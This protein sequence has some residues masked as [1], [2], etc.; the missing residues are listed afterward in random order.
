[1]VRLLEETATLFIQDA[2]A[3]NTRTADS[4]KSSV[5]LSSVLIALALLLSIVL[6]VI[7]TRLITR[8]LKELQGLMKRAEEG[9]LTASAAYRSKDE[10]GQINTSFNTM[11][12]GLKNMMRGVSESAE[13]LS[14]SSQQMSASADQTAH[15]SQMIA[16]T[17]GEIAAG[18]DV[19]AESITL[20]TQSV[21]TMS[22]EIAEA[23][24]SG[25]EMT[26]LMEQ[27]ASST[28]RGV[29]AVEQILAQ[30]REID[31]S[32]SA[33]RQIVGNLGSLS[34]EINTI[35]TTINEIA[36]QTNLLSLNASIEAARAGEH[37][38]GFAVVAGEIRKLAE[39]TGT[40]SLQITE[41]INHIRQQTA[42]AVESMEQGSGI[43]SH[44]VAQSE[45]VSEAFT[46]I[47]TSIQAAS[48]QTEQ[49]TQVI[50]H[51]AQES[52]E[53]A[54]SMSTVNE[55]SRK[56][57]ADVQGTSEASLEQLTAM[58]EMSSS[59]QYLATLAEDLQKHLARFRL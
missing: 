55:I 54:R 36:T 13:I 33:S 45:V 17:S 21:R 51:V 48:E 42:S 4:A 49:I 32:V 9:D 12:D 35:I 39:A 40:S 23:R 58:G 22:Y 18:F 14:A 30:M 41:I 28:E 24:Y 43:V 52:E 31:S 3:H 8:P 37:G 15:A 2:S 56:G 27:A 53:V 7:I 1:M 5:T 26:R 29:D 16:E 50:G 57:A 44:G 11:L 10:I 46:A 47:Q 19:Q 25:Q 20:T 38:R 34:E 59:A 6:S